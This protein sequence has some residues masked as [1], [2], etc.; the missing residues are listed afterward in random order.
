MSATHTLDGI[1]LP[2]AGTWE[3]DAGHAEVAFVGRHLMLT[4]VRGRF[5]DVAGTI[6]VSDEPE[7][8]AVAVTIGMASV[9]SGGP[10]RDEHLRSGDFFDVENHPTAT[11]RSTRVAWNGTTG[12]LSGDL[13]IK[14]VTRPVTLHVDYL[15]HVRDPWGADRAVFSAHGTVNREDWELTWNMVLD[16]GGLLVSKEIRV[17]IEIEAVRQP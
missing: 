17:E 14:D 4:K 9:T 13:T 8:T 1:D 12:T 11:F 6:V 15:G 2:A 5:T 7:D 10:A 3:I 16:G